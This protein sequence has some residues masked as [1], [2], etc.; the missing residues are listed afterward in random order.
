MHDARIYFFL[1][2]RSLLEELY[3]NWFI[4]FR[5][6]LLPNKQ[7]KHNFFRVNTRPNINEDN[8]DDNDDDKNNHDSK[9]DALV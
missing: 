6:I 5:L 7:K 4:T 3:Q 1:L 8:D 2:A 9:D